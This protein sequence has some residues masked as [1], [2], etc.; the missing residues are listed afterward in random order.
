MRGQETVRPWQARAIGVAG[1]LLLSGLGRT[2]R[3]SWLGQEHEHAGPQHSGGYVYAFW[4]G[5]LLPLAYMMRN[6]GVG[7]LVSEHRDGEYITQIIHR[8]GYRTVRGSTTRGGFRS[9]IELARRARAGQVVAITP[10]GPRGPRQKAQPGVLLVAQRGNVPIVPLGFSAWPRRQLA[11]W[12]RFTIPLPRAHVV[13]SFGPPIWLP[14]GEASETL[15]AE[16]T[17]RVE[18]AITETS[19]AAER[20][21]RVVAGGPEESTDDA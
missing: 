3:T 11:S 12:D 19:R 16:W 2:W 14:Q 1:S 10:D 5:G 4:H 6:R 13:A 21:T 8:M 17:P 20:I 18:H 9:L 7:V 15:I